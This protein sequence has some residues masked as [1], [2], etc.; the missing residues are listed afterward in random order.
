M[1]SL[2]KWQGRAVAACA[3]GPPSLKRLQLVMLG[4][5]DVTQT[6][7]PTLVS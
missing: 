6:L 1:V 5:L 7:E 3:A 2:V 4:E